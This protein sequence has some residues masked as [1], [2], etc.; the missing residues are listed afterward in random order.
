MNSEELEEER[1]F[2]FI[3]GRMKEGILLKVQT[4][5]LT[6]SHTGHLAVLYTHRHTYQS[7]LGLYRW[8]LPL[9]NQT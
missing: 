3:G 2:F 9:F 6:H 1:I 7:F 8:W 5:S 4:L